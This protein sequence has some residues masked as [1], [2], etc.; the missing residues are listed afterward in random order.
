MFYRMISR[1]RDEWFA[2]PDCTVTALI[3]YMENRGQLRDAQIDAINIS[4]FEDC[5]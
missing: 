3:E 4:V 1:K 5:L 2:S